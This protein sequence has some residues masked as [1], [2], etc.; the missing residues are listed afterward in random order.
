MGWARRW[1]KIIGLVLLTVVLY[2]GANLFLVWRAS[3]LDQART[4]QAIIVLG[5]AQYAGVPSPDLTARLS[6]A[7]E[8]WRH[9][10][11][12][13]IVVT[14]GREGGDPYTEA[15][16]SAAWLA[17]HGVPQGDILREV[18]GRNTWESLDASAEF[19][20]DRDIHRVLLVSDPYHSE[21]IRLMASELGLQPF[22]SPTRT[23][24]ISG[25]AL[26]PYVVKETLEV[27]LGRLTGFRLIGH[28]SATSPGGPPASG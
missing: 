24:P 12:P 21:R 23:S 8:L 6:H 26:V 20:K 19:L 2:L 28:L 3:R 9:G 22:V 17:L 1:L 11:A 14:G 25:S 27:S 15:G 4:V 18:S 5:S 16:V 13:V 7:L 10:L